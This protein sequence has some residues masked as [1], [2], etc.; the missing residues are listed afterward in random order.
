MRIVRG[1]GKILEALEMFDQVTR[2]AIMI[3]VVAIKTRKLVEAVRGVPK[4]SA[5]LLLLC[6]GQLLE[7][8]H[9]QAEHL[10]D[11]DRLLNDRRR[12]IRSLERNAGKLPIEPP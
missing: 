1:A 10:K 6:F 9:R 3:V 11:I 4:F 8:K 7:V 2:D 12:F 5:D